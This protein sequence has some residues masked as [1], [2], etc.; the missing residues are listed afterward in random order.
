MQPNLKLVIP[1][2]LSGTRLD[3]ALHLLLPDFTRSTL[4]ELIR[5]GS[6]E[7]SR[8]KC[9]AHSTVQEGDKL[10][11]SLPEPESIE[12]KPEKIDLNILYE[13]KDI[14]VVNKQ[15]DLVVHP[16][17]G[18][19]EHTLVQ[20]LLAHTSNL[21][22]INGPLRPGIVHR[23]D[24]ETSGCLVVA[25]NNEAHHALTQQFE[26]RLVKKIYWSLV[27]GEWR[28]GKRKIEKAIGRHPVARKRMSVREVGG[29][30][31]VTLVQPLEVFDSFSLLEIQ[32][33]TGRTHQIRVHLS[34]VGHP[35]LGDRQYS[36]G[37]KL[38]KL[39]ITVPRQMLHAHVL[40]FVHPKTGKKMQFTSPLPHDMI[41]ILEF[42]R[43]E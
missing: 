30:E 12:I 13:D 11:V 26:K 28:L 16:A 5:K 10:K 24:K 6:V 34:S 9:K 40:G 29:K 25:K 22:D 32:L 15:P 23:L 4:Q 19:M 21:S 18:N 43:N 20:G 36:R 7:W 37:K 14:L 31:A 39:P 35:V 41:K 27:V 8:G 33:K 1:A 38:R 2:K 17:P 3:K 42:L